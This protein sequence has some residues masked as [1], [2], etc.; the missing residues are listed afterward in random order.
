MWSRT[1]QTPR[2]TRMAVTIHNTNRMM[3]NRYHTSTTTNTTAMMAAAI[4]PKKARMK[5]RR[6]LNICLID[7]EDFENVIARV[8][9]L[10][11]HSQR[12]C[13]FPRCVCISLNRC[14][15]CTTFVTQILNSPSPFRLCFN[16]TDHEKILSGFTTKSNSFSKFPACSAYC[17]CCG[18]NYLRLDNLKK[19]LMPCTV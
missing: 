17:V 8:A 12:D 7:V 6:D 5:V 16:F 10:T 19:K 2:T 14:P 11:I 4:D 9:R 18:F 15:R 1:Q 3:A 13:I